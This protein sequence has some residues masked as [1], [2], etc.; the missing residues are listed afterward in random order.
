MEDK[1]LAA[2]PLG[3]Q[4]LGKTPQEVVVLLLRL[5]S[6]RQ[7][8]RLQWKQTYPYLVETFERYLPRSMPALFPD[9]HELGHGL[10][11]KS[12]L[13]SLLNSTYLLL[14]KQSWQGSVGAAF[15]LFLSMTTCGDFLSRRAC[16]AL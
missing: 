7:V 2:L 13:L 8:C 9:S 10:S 15:Y 6:F 14:R 11:S 12:F 4:V 16:D 1:R 5:L 3:K